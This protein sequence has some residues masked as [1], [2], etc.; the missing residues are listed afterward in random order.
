MSGVF[1][2]KNIYCTHNIL[3]GKPQ[4]KRPLR[5]SK[6]K[7]EYNIKTDLKEIEDVVS[8]DLAPDRDQ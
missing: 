3:V 2:M 1:N 4:G 8:I 5:I 7:W 6:R